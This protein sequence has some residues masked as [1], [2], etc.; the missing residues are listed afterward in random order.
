MQKLNRQGGFTLVELLV[1]I[2]IIALLIALLLP[3]LSQARRAAQAAACLS[4]MRQLGVAM[5]AYTT[6]GHDTLPYHYSDQYSSPRGVLGGWAIDLWVLFDNQQLPAGPSMTIDTLNGVAQANVMSAPILRCPGE[7]ADYFADP[8]GTTGV[9]PSTACVY[10]N[11]LTG[12]AFTNCGGDPR[13]GVVGYQNPSLQLFTH[14]QFNGQYPD[15][16]G[17]LPPGTVPCQGTRIGLPHLQQRT[18]QAR[19]P[20]NTWLGFDGTWA[21]ISVCTPCFRHPNLSS[22]FVYLDCHAQ[23]VRPG[24]IDGGNLPIIGNGISDARERMDQ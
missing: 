4:N 11:G 3:A 21:D 20:A 12:N 8:A 18:D 9:I 22:N 16:A 14:Y 6:D 24:D 13:S 10:R 1:V 7:P 15:Y 17:G 2:S 19:Q 23:S 5:S